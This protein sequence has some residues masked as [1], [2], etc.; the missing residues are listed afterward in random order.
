[1]AHSNHIKDLQN[2]IKKGKEQGKDN[3]DRKTIIVK[4][5]SKEY[6]NLNKLIKLAN[7]NT[8]TKVTKQSIIYNVLL[9]S[10]ALDTI[11]DN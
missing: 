10:G 2:E 3:S 5:S 7:S 9:E 11:K 6:T 8:N 1:M 4:V